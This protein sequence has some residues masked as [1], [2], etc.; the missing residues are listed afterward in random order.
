M[1]YVYIAG[2]D[3]KTW[4]DI[5]VN[6]WQTLLSQG[7][8]ERPSYERHKGK[9]V[10]AIAG[11]GLA[12]R[13]AER[14]KR[15]FRLVSRV[16]EASAGFGGVTLIV[17]AAHGGPET[18]TPSGPGWDGVYKAFDIISPWTVGRYTDVT[19]FDAFLKQ[20]IEPDIAE[21]KRPASTIC[22]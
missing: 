12:D 14:P 6:D 11:I 8:V 13:P 4:A 2:A 3:P 9:P 1:T 7:F 15:R 5:L 21:T 19:S 16:R 22:P 20:R 10:L 17:S 18:A